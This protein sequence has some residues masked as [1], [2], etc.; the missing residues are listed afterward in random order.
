MSL[1]FISPISPCFSLSLSLFLIMYLS[2]V[3]CFP[4]LSFLSPLSLFL[5]PPISLSNFPFLCFLVFYYFLCLSF[6]LHLFLFFFSLYLS[7]SFPCIF[8]SLF[9]VSFSLVSLYLSLSFPLCLFLFYLPISSFDFTVLLGYIK[10]LIFDHD[11]DLFKNA[12]YKIV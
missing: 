9:P 1:N 7:L 3:S 4:S 10:Q 11:K 8:L 2:L 12:L 6:S 5:V